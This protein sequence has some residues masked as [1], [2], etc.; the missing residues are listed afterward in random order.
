MSVPRVY[1]FRQLFDMNGVFLEAETTALLRH[2]KIVDVLRLCSIQTTK[3]STVSIV[4]PFP[5][6]LAFDTVKFKEMCR[7][8]KAKSS[9]SSVLNSLRQIDMV[10][11][12]DVKLS[13]E[14]IAKLKQYITEKVPQYDGISFRSIKRSAT[15]SVITILTDGQYCAN[16][17]RCHNREHI[18]FVIKNGCMYQK[19]HCKCATTEGRFYGQCRLFSCPINGYDKTPEK[20]PTIIR[21]YFDAG[22]SSATETATRVRR[23]SNSSVATNASTTSSSRPTKP[24]QRALTREEDDEFRRAEEQCKFFS[25]PPPSASAKKAVRKKRFAA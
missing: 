4:S 23:G 5:A 16:V 17:G 22:L 7:D 24:E 6:W 19:C 18:Y 14:Q 20:L 3:A 21:S 2:T 13:D 15:G 25:T 8:G 9:N 10:K 1:E 12:D 11:G